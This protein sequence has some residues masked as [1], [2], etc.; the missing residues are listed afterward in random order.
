MVFHAGTKIHN[1]QVLTAGG[2]VI[3]VTSFADNVTNAFNKSFETVNKID[4]SGKYFRN[5]LGKDLERYLI[6]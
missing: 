1:N 6:K 4:F 5:D 2:R 3:A